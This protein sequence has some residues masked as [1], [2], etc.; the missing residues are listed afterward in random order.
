M[1]NTERIEQILLYNIFNVL[2]ILLI[3][4]TLN[5]QAIVEIE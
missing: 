1:V 2:Y 5:P 4:K 3:T